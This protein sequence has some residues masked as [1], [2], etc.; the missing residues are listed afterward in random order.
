[1]KVDFKSK[2]GWKWKGTII[3]FNIFITL[4]KDIPE[5]IGS[6]NIKLFNYRICIR[7]I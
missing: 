2:K 3:I 5:Q 7:K 4:W 6:V 1:M